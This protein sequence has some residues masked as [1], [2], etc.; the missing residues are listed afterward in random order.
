MVVLSECY[1]Q[2]LEKK[3]IVLSFARNISPKAFKRYVDD[4]HVRFENK[5]NSL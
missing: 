3:S 2:K 5:E 1:L 4:S